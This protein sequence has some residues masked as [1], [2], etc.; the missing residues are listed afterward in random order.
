MPSTILKT[1]FTGHNGAQLAARV[2]LPTGAV[3]G[4]ALFAHCFTCS[5]DL[6]AARHIAAE[7][8]GHGIGVMRFDFTGL[9]RSQ[10]EFA[11]TN[12][13]SNVR[14]L[15]AA[16]QHL[17]AEFEAPALLIGHSLGGAAVL[18]AASDIASAQA[19][20]TIGAPSDV[21]HVLHNFGS[22]IEKIRENGEAEVTLGGRPFT[23]KKQFIDDAEEHVLTDKVANLGKALL[24]LHA[25]LD[26]IVGIDNA[27]RIFVAAKHP[28]SFVA[29]DGADHLVSRKRDAAFAAKI[30]AAW[31]DKHVRA[32]EVG[33]EAGRELVTVAETGF[34]KFQNAVRTGRHK[35]LADEP[36]SVGGDDTGP[37]PYDYLSVAL[38]ACT[39]MTLRIYAEF[40][41]VDLPRVS[42][43]VT[44]G[45]V[46]ADHCTDCGSV[47]EG[48]SGKIDR[49]E[50]T[51]TVHGDVPPELAD[52]LVEI[53]DKCPVHKTLTAGAA[54]VT[55]V[56]G[57]SG[58]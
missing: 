32:D 26:D 53:A 23:I 5:K 48:K 38:G 3:R 14:D 18:A 44:H 4:F 9:G 42:V 29:L 37:S 34:G 21:G 7:L 54:V 13:S 19:V 39:T 20:V 1:T 55:K 35:L 17:E 30:I 36:V 56:A 43:A 2:D 50:R 52:K 45:K 12:F 27:S 25:P 11:N 51:I 47:A 40:K 58:D 8:A 24:V 28:K 41:K 49:F 46:K 33:S 31:A 22:S 57:P 16:A 6:A 10:G 15:V